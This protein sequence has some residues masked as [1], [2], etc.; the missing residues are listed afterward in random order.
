MLELSQKLTEIGSSMQY[1]GYKMMPLSFIAY[2]ILRILELRWKNK[3]ISKLVKGIWYLAV[4][5]GTLDG[6]IRIEQ[7]VVM[8]LFFDAFD[9]F[10]EYRE[11][12]RKI[13]SND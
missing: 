9:S 5:V 1:L 4:A 13:T 6:D 2:F 7:L 10:I 8:M 11:D 12:K 3:H